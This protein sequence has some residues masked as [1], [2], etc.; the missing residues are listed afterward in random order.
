MKKC[1]TLIGKITNKFLNFPIKNILLGK[2]FE[3][4]PIIVPDVE[5]LKPMWLCGCAG[6]FVSL[7]SVVSSTPADLNEE[8]CLISPDSIL[9]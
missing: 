1:D 3:K 8:F 6:V 7:H 5:F 9:M 4:R 2:T